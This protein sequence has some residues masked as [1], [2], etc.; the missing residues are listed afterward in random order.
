MSPTQV[1]TSMMGHQQPQVSQHQQHQPYHHHYPQPQQS[2]HPPPPPHQGMATTTTATAPSQTPLPP[3]PQQQQ[4]PL[5]TT[6]TTAGTMKIDPTD[7]GCQFVQQYYTVLNQDPGRLH[8]FY[9]KHSSFTYG[10]E[11]EFAL[12]A[13]G[14]TDIHSRIIGL[15]FDDCKVT[16]NN[17]DCQTSLNGGIIILVTGQLLNRNGV[18]K[19]FAQSFFLAEQPNGYYVL[20]DILRIQKEKP[21]IDDYPPS[22]LSSHRKEFMKEELPPSG[23]PLMREEPSLA[24]A[25]VSKESRSVPVLA[26]SKPE[27]VLPPAVTMTTTTTTRKEEE[28]LRGQPKPTIQPTKPITSAATATISAKENVAAGTAIAPSVTAPSKPKTWASL[29]AV[30]KEQWGDNV[31]QVTG[32]S[33]VVESATPTKQ[34]APTATDISSRTERK[35][36]AEKYGGSGRPP[37]HDMNTASTV[38]VKNVTSNV[39]EETLRAV[40]REFGQIKTVLII[41]AKHS[42]F[43]EFD[44]PQAARKVVAIKTLKAGDVELSFEAK[45]GPRQHPATG[46]SNGRRTLSSGNPTEPSSSSG[47]RRVRRDKPATT[48]RPPRAKSEKKPPTQ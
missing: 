30:G 17:L 6:G 14:Q 28:D 2:Y 19:K 23:S 34:Q 42:A 29:A 48:E 39:T 35:S 40:L 7:V 12:P 24:S 43:V 13:I 4:Q 21:G 5:P 8:C 16:I 27:V 46:S 38:F 44:E 37:H 41:S 45:Q 18:A 32:T 1:D 22:A 11:G 25:T 26:E 36:T 10:I 20:N 33:V 3:P 31:S 47:P 15:G 9:K